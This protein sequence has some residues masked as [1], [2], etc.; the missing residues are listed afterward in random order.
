MVNDIIEKWPE[1]AVYVKWSKLFRFKKEEAYKYD[2]Y[3]DA[4]E[5]V[6]T[7]FWA[8]CRDETAIPKLPW[9]CKSRRVHISSTFRE[10][11]N[12]TH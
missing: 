1:R 9:D 11:W 2:N 4:R 7:W 10:K 6:S 8:I 3:V 12:K 5:P